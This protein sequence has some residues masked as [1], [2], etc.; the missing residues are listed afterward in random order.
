[1]GTDGKEKSKTRAQQRAAGTKKTALFDMVNRNYA[2]TRLARPSACLGAPSRQPSRVPAK[3]APRRRFGHGIGSRARAGTQGPHDMTYVLMFRFALFGAGS[4]VSLRSPGTRE[5]KAD[6][7]SRLG[8]A[9]LAIA[10]FSSSA[11]A[12]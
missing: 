1:M 7:R 2:A 12:P 3:R 11:S 10:I 9:F 4:R 6:T 5:W 8:R